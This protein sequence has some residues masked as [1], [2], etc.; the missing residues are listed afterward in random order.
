MPG[1]QPPQVRSLELWDLQLGD[2]K[3]RNSHSEE[4]KWAILAV[5]PPSLAAFSSREAAKPVTFPEELEIT[6]RSAL[7]LDWPQFFAMCSWDFTLVVFKEKKKRSGSDSDK[8]F[9][10][11]KMK[12]L[13]HE[14]PTFWSIW[15][16]LITDCFD[17]RLAGILYTTLEEASPLTDMQLY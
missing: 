7:F 9:I 10:K 8:N 4:K 13:Q 2:K 6:K 16:P 5:S 11:N 17:R 1:F 12:Y 15:L 14:N 3:P